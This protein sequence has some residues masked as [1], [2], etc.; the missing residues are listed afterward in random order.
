MRVVVLGAGVVGEAVA[1]DLSHIAPVAD[2]T[3]AVGAASVHGNQEKT[4][5]H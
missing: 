1:W 4:S 2:V 5:W 3:V